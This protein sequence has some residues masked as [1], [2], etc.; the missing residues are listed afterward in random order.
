[1][2]DKYMLMVCLE[3]DLHII[4]GWKMDNS[5]YAS[6]IHVV[7][8]QQAEVSTNTGDIRTLSSIAAHYVVT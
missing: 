4:L 2:I 3:L 5:K 8:F 1:M 6:A 7:S